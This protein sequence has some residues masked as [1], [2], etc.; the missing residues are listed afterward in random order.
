[1]GRKKAYYGSGNRRGGKSSVQELA[2]AVHMSDPEKGLEF[3]NSL[4]SMEELGGFPALMEESPKNQGIMCMQ[5]CGYSQRFIAKTFGMTQPAVSQIVNRIDPAGLFRIS[6]KAK[7]A[8]ITQL[9]KNIS[10]EALASIT[11]EDMME[12]TA[13]ERV[14]M[15]DM[16]VN[17]SQKL[18]QSKHRDFGGSRLDALLAEME[19]E[20]EIDV[21]GSPLEDVD[22]DGSEDV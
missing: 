11:Y 9:A 16:A 1:M 12:H 14:R 10:N 19:R 5:A 20:S 2:E 13:L 7:N 15:A 18:N 21:S 22:G 17:I 6:T 3:T 4:M 8:L